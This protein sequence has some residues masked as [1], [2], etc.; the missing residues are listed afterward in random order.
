MNVGFQGLSKDK[1]STI[2]HG[3][4]GEPAS[5]NLPG[6]QAQTTSV[7]PAVA[8]N[9]VTPVLSSLLQKTE[10][11]GLPGATSAVTSAANAGLQGGNVKDMG[12][13]ALSAALSEAAS[14]T[15]SNALPG[16]PGIGQVGTATVKESLSPNPNLARA[17]IQSAV[18]TAASIIGSAMGPFAGMAA[19]GLADYFTSKSLKDGWLGDMADSRS[20]ESKR[21]AVESGWDVGVDTTAG[22]ASTQGAMNDM[23]V[24]GS[25]SG[26]GFGLDSA[27]DSTTTGVM[28]KQGQAALS[29]SGY[30]DKMD[31]MDAQVDS[32]LNDT[33]S[34]NDN[35]EGGFN[36]GEGGNGGYG[37]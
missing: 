16:L 18:P 10:L 26:Y 2:L 22:L 27:Y 5:V 8:S 23:G 20:Q 4:G 13:S 32:M 12:I 37:R 35:D 11:A 3:Q 30:F 34:D 21:D 29:L 9:L 17:A 1:Q 25:K 33:E 15:L 14:R 7:S 24:K 28:D 31:E 19:G 6:T 36:D